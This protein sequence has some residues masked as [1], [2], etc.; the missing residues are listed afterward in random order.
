MLKN[1]NK[2]VSLGKKT[3]KEEEISYVETGKNFCEIT[4]NQPFQNSSMQ[5][6]PNPQPNLQNKRRYFEELMMQKQHHLSELNK[7]N[8]EFQ[9]N[10]G[11]VPN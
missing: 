6:H 7:I 9:D 8:R 11:M 1:I 5:T 3:E 10:F 2:R 4:H